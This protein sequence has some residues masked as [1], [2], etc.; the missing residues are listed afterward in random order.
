MSACGYNVYMGACHDMKARV[1]KRGNSTSVQI[2]VAVLHA[3]KLRRGQSV[4]VHEESGR[5]VI[6][7]VH[8]REYSLEKLLQGITHKNLHDK[9]DFGKHAGRE[10]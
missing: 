5:I 7:P 3:A 6:E 8:R 1:R 10:A 2:P 9:A 4:D